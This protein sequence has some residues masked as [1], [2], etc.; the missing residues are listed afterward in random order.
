MIMKN[1]ILTIIG[2]VI[3]LMA[4]NVK[5][6]VFSDI[7]DMAQQMF[8]NNPSNTWDVSTYALNNLNS[9]AQDA[10]KG[11]GAGAKIGYWLN[12]SVGTTLDVSYCNST[13]TFASLSL[14]ARGTI[15]ISSFGTISPYV[16]AGPGYSF[17]KS[18][19]GIEQSVVAVAGSGATLH[20]NKLT[21]FDFFGEYAHITTTPDAQDRI[22][23]GI[24][25][26]F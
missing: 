10:A 24:T 20:I 26:R 12:P 11:W 5:A 6:S 8:N 4:V 7:T 22:Q 21:W 19:T 23:F 15:N 18:E 2:A 17:T 25:R 9:T 13:W 16:Y 1:K 14:T 3:V